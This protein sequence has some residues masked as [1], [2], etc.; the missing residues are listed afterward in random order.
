MLKQALNTNCQ[1]LDEQ[2]LVNVLFIQQRK[3][4]TKK[5]KQRDY[6]Q[7]NDDQANLI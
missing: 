1:T 6:K 2:M 4:E 7:R 3:I 5:C